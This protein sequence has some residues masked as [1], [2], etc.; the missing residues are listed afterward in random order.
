L[1]PA[2]DKALVGQPLGSRIMII[3]PPDMAYGAQGSPP[4]IPANAT[5]VFVVDVLGVDSAA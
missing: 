4:T 3:A 5:L 2:W 1:I